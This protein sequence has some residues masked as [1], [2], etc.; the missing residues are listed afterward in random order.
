[1]VVRVQVPPTAPFLLMDERLIETVKQWNM[2]A[3]LPLQVGDFILRKDFSEAS[4]QDGDYAV[5]FAYVNERKGW[6]VEGVYHNGSGDFSV[7]TDIGMLEFTLIEFITDDFA[8]F[9]KMVEK[10]LPHIIE[11]HYVHCREDFSVIL[12]NKGVPD[13]DWQDLLPLEYA[14]FERIIEPSEAVRIINGSYMVVAYY[15]AS[16]RSGLS[17]MYNLLRDDFFAERR[18]RNFPNLVHDFDSK[19]VDELSTAL[20]ENLRSVLDDVRGQIK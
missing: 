15:D 17:I 9:A 8:T 3:S 12:T 2:D 11:T 4:L 18:V 7:R 19:T 1:M 10:R 16:T 20:S 13:G 5:I 14:G 6:T